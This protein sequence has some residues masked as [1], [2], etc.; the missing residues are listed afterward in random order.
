MIKAIYN[1]PT[2]NIKLNGEMAD[3]YSSAINNERRMLTLNTFIQHRTRS[4]SQSIGQKE[5]I[6]GI[7]IGKKEVKLSLFAD[8]MISHV[9]NPKYSTE[10]P[11]SLI[12]KY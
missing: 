7:Q 4:P 10:K 8:D 5:E 1:K 11:L 2:A 12:H 6:K 3:T 9:D